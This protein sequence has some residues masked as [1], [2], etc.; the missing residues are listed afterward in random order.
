MRLAAA[1]LPLLLTVVI[2]TP[3]RAVASDLPSALEPAVRELIR[4]RAAAVETAPDDAFAHARLGAAYEG[5]LLWAEAR[6]AYRRAAE[7]DPGEALWRLHEAIATRQAG[8]FPGAV[9]LLR[10]VARQAPA[11]AAAQQRLGLALLE[12]GDLEEARGAFGRLSEL[13][14]ELPQGWS[15]LGEVLLALRQPGEALPLLERAVALAPQDRRARYLLGLAYRGVGRLEEARVELAR[16]VGAATAYLPDPFT[17]QVDEA[18]V[19]LT[20]RV[21]RAQAL[22]QARRPGEAEALLEAVLTDHPENVT[23][24]N[25]L[26]IAR[27]HLGDLESARELLERALEIDDRRFSTYL[28]LASWAQRSGQP[29]RALELTAEAVARGP[30]VARAHVGHAQSLLRLGRLAEAAESLDRALE[31]DFRDPQAM[32]TLGAVRLR[33]GQP[34]KALPVYERLAELYPEAF[35]AHLALARLY[36]AGG[37][38]GAARRA[39]EAA[40]ALAPEHPEVAAL[41]AQLAAI[42]EEPPPASVANAGGSEAA[43]SLAEPGPRSVGPAPASEEAPAERRDLWF[44]DVA[45]ALGVDFR[46]VRSTTDRSWF[47]EIMGGGGGWLDYDGDGD[48]DLYLVQGGDLAATGDAADPTDRLYRNDGAAGFVDVTR[49]ARVAL[50]GWGMG[51][52]AGDVDG[53]GDLDLHVTRVGANLLLENLGDGTFADVSV[54]AGVDRLTEIEKFLDTVTICPNQIGQRAALWG[55]Q[56]LG[57]WLA[58]ERL[59]ILDR[60]AAIANHFPKMAAKGWRLL[61]CGAY[62]AYVTHPFDI[63]SDQLAQKL[64]PK[65]GVLLL[66]GTMFMP[67]DMPGGARQLRIAFANI[68][69]T[70]V[71]ALFDR[72]AAVDL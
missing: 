71:A 1:V 36:L 32:L 57:D 53:D 20:A 30:E 64:V 45:G 24:L 11:V 26:A 8:D 4:E 14:P 19:H 39:L 7:L 31:L 38:P 5:N 40:R 66:P 25:N 27:M 60:R 48:L 33:L 49:R 21:D 34:E 23:V 16:G 69:R 15:G 29:E 55:M 22:L 44:A 42:G 9:A 62:F 47:P 6:D 28:N 10:E 65:A 35:P 46:H 68:D 37:D 41:A 54:V 56:N 2:A 3:S 50:P 58:G 61:G 17:A 13:R 51:V 72:L 52:A 43:R 12:T 18:A 67:D 59:E 70:G 63:P